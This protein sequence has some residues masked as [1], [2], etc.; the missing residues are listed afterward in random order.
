MHGKFMKYVATVMLWSCEFCK[1]ITV[2]RFENT[3]QVTDELVCI[4][5]SKVIL[6][7]R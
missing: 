5:G 4:N 6:F 1:H 3:G 7:N 2:M